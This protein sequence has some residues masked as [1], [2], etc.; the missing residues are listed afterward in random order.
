MFR[1]RY[2]VSLKHVCLQPPVLQGRVLIQAVNTPPAWAQV[3]GGVGEEGA[4]LRTVESYNRA[5]HKWVVFP[6]MQSAREGC[7][8]YALPDGRIGVFGGY[9]SGGKLLR[10]C[11]AFSFRT[12]EWE[13]LPPMLQARHSFGICAVAGGVCVF[14]GWS[15]GADRGGGAEGALRS[16]QVLDVASAQWSR[17]PDMPRAR[18]CCGAAAVELPTDK[19]SS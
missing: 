13:A 19:T 9:G 17:L 4:R 11:E 12:H 14:G 1:D 15:D 3:A 5:L 10:S 6:P 18:E 8:C 2:C 7:G 16:A